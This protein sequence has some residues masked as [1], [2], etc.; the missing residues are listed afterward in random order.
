M[1]A[2]N[3]KQ[4]AASQTASTL[5]QQGSG[6]Q[7]DWLDGLLVTP[8]NTSPGQVLILDNATSYTVFAGGASSVTSLV[9]FVIPW[10][11]LS[12]SGAWKVTTGADVSVMAFGRF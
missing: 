10:G 2:V 9:P 1:Y 11:A 5:S 3:F 12:R 7:G 8:A 6:A 4:V